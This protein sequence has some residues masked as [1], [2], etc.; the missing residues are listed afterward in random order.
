MNYVVRMIDNESKTITA[1]S[2]ELDQYGYV[3]FLDASAKAIAT[4]S[5]SRWIWVEKQEVVT[6]G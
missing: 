6:A 4:I 5:S 2:Y 1:E 3:H